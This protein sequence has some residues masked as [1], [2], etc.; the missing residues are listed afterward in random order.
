MTKFFA[1]AGS[2]RSVWM[3]VVIALW[4]V[5]VLF[6]YVLLFGPPEFWLFLD[7]LG[8]SS[9]LQAWKSWLEPFFTADYL[10]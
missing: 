10:S 7:R 9:I 4:M 5:L 1:L 3:K 6:T 2:I 8:L